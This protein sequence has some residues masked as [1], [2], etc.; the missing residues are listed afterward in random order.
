MVAIAQELGLNFNEEAI[1]S[2]LLL[3][4]NGASPENIVKMLEDVKTEIN[5]I[6]K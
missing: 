1:E 4:E 2:M 5:Q 6:R 3:L